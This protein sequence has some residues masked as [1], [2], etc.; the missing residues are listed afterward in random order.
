MAPVTFGSRT[1]ADIPFVLVHLNNVARLRVEVFDPG[2]KRSL[3][4]TLEQD[5]VPRDQVENLLSAS[6]G[7]TTA[8][9]LD[10]TVRRGRQHVR[11]PDGDYPL[12]VSAERPPS[13]RRDPPETSTSPVFG[14]GAASASRTRSGLSR[15]PGVVRH[16]PRARGRVEPCSEI[17]PQETE[18][19]K[20]VKL[21]DLRPERGGG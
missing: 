7:L 15:A 8:L 5:Y 17:D 20:V 1:G 4:V 2:R 13:R 9:P 12:V 10:G 19:S 16:G 11:L 6:W 21:G 18:M 14:S 3:G